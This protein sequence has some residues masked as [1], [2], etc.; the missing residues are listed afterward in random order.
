MI[1][2]MF[3]I[4]ITGNTNIDYQW[5]KPL[6]LKIKD[7]NFLKNHIIGIQ[8]KQNNEL[9]LYLRVYDFIIEFGKAEYIDNSFF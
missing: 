1:F 3:S 4:R 2:I 7:D 8:I 6:L 5:L 9:I